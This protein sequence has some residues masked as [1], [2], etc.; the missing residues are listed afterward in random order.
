LEKFGL[1]SSTK[2]GK[3]KT[4]KYLIE[5]SSTEGFINIEA[6][7][8]SISPLN[9]KFNSTTKKHQNI[10]K[11]KSKISP[12]SIKSDSKSDEVVAEPFKQ[13]TSPTPVSEGKLYLYLFFYL[14][15]NYRK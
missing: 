15:K 9:H 12:S 4:E 10:Y 6:S 11:E 7:P 1:H 8:P 2:G 13:N 5:K 3:H 14:F